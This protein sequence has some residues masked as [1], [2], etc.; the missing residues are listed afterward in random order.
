MSFY[1]M[2]HSNCRLRGKKPPWL[3]MHPAT[4]PHIGTP[5]AICSRKDIKIS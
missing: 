1:T 2:T 5:Q 4:S 3:Q